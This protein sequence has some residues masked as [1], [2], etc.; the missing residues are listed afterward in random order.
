MHANGSPLGLGDLPDELLSQIL[1]ILPSQ[2]D[3]CA[4]CLVN[5]RI[6]SVADP[7]LHKTILFDEPKHHFTFSESLV[8]RP[9]RGSLIRTVRLEYPSSELTDF[10]SMKD[11]SYRIDG[12]S[13]TIS[14]MSNLENLVV[15]VP[16][17][18]C[19]GLGTIFNG[20]FDLAYLK[21]CESTIH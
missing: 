17:S 20:P 2:S 21:S 19:R 13:H 4:M 5:R 16:E 8:T 10:M 15:S 11:G 6:N 1:E 12:L 18:L 3:V 7:I 9:R 14:T